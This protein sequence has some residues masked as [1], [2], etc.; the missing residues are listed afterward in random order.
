MQEMTDIDGVDESLTRRE[1]LAAGA[2]IS[3]RGCR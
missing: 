3:H 2:R 1:F